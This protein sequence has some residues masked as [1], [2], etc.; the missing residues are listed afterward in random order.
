MEWEVRVMNPLLKKDNQI[1]SLNKKGI[2][3]F[4]T[5]YVASLFLI[6]RE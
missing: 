2:I 5:I 3:I 4:F 6:Q 1:S